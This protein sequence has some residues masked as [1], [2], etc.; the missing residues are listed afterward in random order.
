M[1]CG[2]N[3][4]KQAPDMVTP[5]LLSASGGHHEIVRLL[6]TNGAVVDHMDIVRNVFHFYRSVFEQFHIYRKAIRH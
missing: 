1:D 2:A 6:L 4:N 3:A 5:L